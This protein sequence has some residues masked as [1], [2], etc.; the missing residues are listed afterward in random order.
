MRTPP[1]PSATL[2]SM[3]AA[4]QQMQPVLPWKNAGRGSP[5]PP[6]CVIARP[7]MKRR[8][9]VKCPRSTAC[10]SPVSA[11]PASR[12]VV[13]PRLSIA[14]R[15]SFACAAI[16]VCG[17]SVSRKKSGIVAVT[18]TWA[19]IRPGSS[20]RPARSITC[21]SAVT[22]R[23]GPTASMRSPRIATD[24][25]GRSVA[26]TLSN[27]L[28]LRRISRGGMRGLSRGGNEDF[29]PYARAAR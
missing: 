26:V 28:A 2:P 18:C 24:V 7:A 11:P 25:P 13:K 29:T 10:T 6:V 3:P 19:S 1:T 12:T 8:G 5:W 27:R 15:M 9:P 21:A 22:G 4:P 16:S 20:V 14:A 17:S 23:S